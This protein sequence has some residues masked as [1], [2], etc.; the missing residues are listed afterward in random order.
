MFDLRLSV[1]L[2]LRLRACLHW[3]ALLFALLACTIDVC[4]S[5][6]CAHV[7]VISAESCFAHFSQRCYPT[8]G[9]VSRVG[10]VSSCT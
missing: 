4:A 1:G 6:A 2:K 9:S 3:N 10:F 7:P 8:G 5:V